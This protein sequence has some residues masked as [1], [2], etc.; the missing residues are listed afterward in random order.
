MTMDPPTRTRPDP[1]TGKELKDWH[2]SSFNVDN[3]KSAVKASIA[4][5]AAAKNSDGDKKETN[6]RWRKMSSLWSCK[7]K[8]ND[9]KNGDHIHENG[10][11]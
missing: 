7:H 1:V 9:K 11:Y 4:A 2:L 3:V 8:P 5:H 10:S 6:S